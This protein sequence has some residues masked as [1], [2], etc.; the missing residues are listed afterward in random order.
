M[1]SFRRRFPRKIYPTKF[2]FLIF[3]AY[4]TFLSSLALCNTSHLTRPIQIIFS[5]L[6]Q[7]N[8]P[9][10]ARYFW[11]TFRSVQVS[12]SYKCSIC[13]YFWKE[14]ILENLQCGSSSI[15]FPHRGTAGIQTFLSTPVTVRSWTITSF[16][17]SMLGVR[18]ICNGVAFSWAHFFVFFLTSW[19][20]QLGRPYWYKC[21]NSQDYI[22][23]TS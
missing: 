10:L 12:A 5:I 14:T 11:S 20:V 13:F 17:C 15:C 1:T 19:S 16:I 2:Y 9:Y 4:S 3:I 6:L 18:G 21:Y 7:H 23:L 22:S 8:I